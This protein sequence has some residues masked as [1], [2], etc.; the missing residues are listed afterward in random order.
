M[1]VTVV[2]VVAA[3]VEVVAVIVLIVVEIVLCGI[4][5]PT[6]LVIVLEGRGIVRPVEVW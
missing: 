2:D 4:V 5:S 6:V 3:V 1:V